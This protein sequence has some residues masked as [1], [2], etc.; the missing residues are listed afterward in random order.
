MTQILSAGPITARELAH[1]GEHDDSIARRLERGK[2]PKTLDGLVRWFVQ[3][4]EEETPERLH[5]D[6][7]WHDKVSGHEREEGVQSVGGSLL[8]SL[9][10]SGAFKLIL[11]ASPSKT[12]ED[13]YYLFPLRSALSRVER[14]RPFM[15]RYLCRLGLAQGDWRR[16]ADD[17]GW[18]HEVM[19]VYIEEA[20]RR[21]WR[22][23][24]ERTTRFS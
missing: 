10:Y 23:T 15:V 12:D 14:R 7:T 17:L 13:G 8:G 1:I 22:E 5:I 3:R 16:V 19:E 2:M 11:E 9:A 4:F 18:V 20:L 21:V 6:E 24:Y